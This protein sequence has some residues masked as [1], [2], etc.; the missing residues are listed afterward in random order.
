MNKD[1]A[2]GNWK[3][4]KGKMKE[5]WGKLTDDDMQVIEGKRDQLV[6]KI[7]ERYGSTKDEAEREVSDWEGQ[8]KDHSW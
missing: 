2:S 8:N 1:E 5:K 4:F 3:Q 6:G 7:Q